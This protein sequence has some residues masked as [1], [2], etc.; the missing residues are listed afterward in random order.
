[1]LANLF[2]DADDSNAARIAA[3]V[4]KFE[5]LLYAGTREQIEGFLSDSP[6]DVLVKMPSLDIL[7]NRLSYNPHIPDWA[8]YANRLDASYIWPLQKIQNKIQEVEMDK[9]HRRK[10]AALG[11]TAMLVGVPHVM[12]KAGDFQRE[13]DVW[14]SGQHQLYLDSRPALTERFA[15]ECRDQ[16]FNAQWTAIQESVDELKAQAKEKPDFAGS[17]RASYAPASEEFMKIC[18]GRRAEDRITAIE[19]QKAYVPLALLAVLGIGGLTFR[20][21]NRRDEGRLAD[22][23]QDL[24]SRK[25]TGPLPAG[26]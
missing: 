25:R 22:L 17:L 9:S 10:L 18:V 8:T 23:N 12:D 19:E 1:M 6:I 14:K 7:E 5:K 2:N 21:N 3:E 4:E 15:A 26:H 24:A 16:D 20:R 11:M 13:V